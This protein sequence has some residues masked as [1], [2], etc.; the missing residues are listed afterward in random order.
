MYR[1]AWDEI[2]EC[3]D[4]GAPVDVGRERGYRVSDRQVLCWS[5]S[6]ARGARFDEDEDRWRIQPDTSDIPREEE[7]QVP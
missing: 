4:C 5:C 2:S 6:I 7:H 1:E 3:V